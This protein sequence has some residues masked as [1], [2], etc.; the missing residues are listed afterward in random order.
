MQR[1]KGQKKE[2]DKK[3]KERATKNPIKPTNMYTVM[4]DKGVKN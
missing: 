3:D 4:M 2:D 1:K